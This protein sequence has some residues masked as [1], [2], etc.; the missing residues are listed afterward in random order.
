[1]ITSHSFKR[2]SAA[3]VM[4]MAAATFASGSPPAFAQSSARGTAGG[5]PEAVVEAV[6][7]PAW[8]E[9]GTDKIPLA[10]GMALRD[11]DRVRTGD[12][13]RIV[14]RMAEGS[15]VKLGEKGSLLLDNMR[16]QRKENVFG[17]TM[18]VFEGAFRFTTNVLVK[19]RGRREVEV[20]ISAVT[21]GIRGTDLWGKAAADRDIVCLIEG[22]IEVRRGDDAPFIMD[23]PLMFY[24]AP[25]NKPPLPVAPVDPKQ[26]AQWATETEIQA[27]RG[28]ARQGGKWKVVLASVDTQQDALKIYDAVRAGGYAAEIRPHEAA[29]KH[30]YDVRL[31]QLPSKAEAQALADALRGKMGVAEPKV[32]M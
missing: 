26:L 23:Q 25:K 1:M 2:L 10:P 4:L 27:G 17:A 19:Y 31:S 11:R 29:G 15:A 14:L 20:T 5:A 22:I 32:T 7:M 30:T 3:S 18:K 9:R 16:M 24:I 21:A 12:N 8:V 6:Q 28:A 13:A